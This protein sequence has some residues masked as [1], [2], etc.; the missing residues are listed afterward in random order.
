MSNN[1]HS[2]TFYGAGK[3]KYVGKIKRKA[4]DAVVG[5]S[6]TV[7]LPGGYNGE[8]NLVQVKAFGDDAKM[9]D[10]IKKDDVVRFTAVPEIYESESKVEGKKDSSVQAIVGVS[11][12]GTEIVVAPSQEP[13]NKVVIVGEIAFAGEINERGANKTKVQDLFVGTR[14]TSPTGKEIFPTLPV[15][16]W[17][18]FA[19]AEYEK[20]KAVEVS[21]Q[22]R[23]EKYV[24]G[25]ENRYS[26]TIVVASVDD[27]HG[28]SLAA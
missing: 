19:K 4:D 10:G 9:M 23:N 12:P 2:A 13:V 3:V 16:A 1:E 7:F 28:I 24:S 18:G 27:G 15:T 5:A 14:K 26:G 11:Y 20:G 22:V 8:P 17:A 25:D 21:G 6:V